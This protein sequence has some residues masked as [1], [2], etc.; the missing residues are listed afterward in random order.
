VVLNVGFHPRLALTYLNMPRK[1]KVYKLHI[2][3]CSNGRFGGITMKRLPF[4]ALLLMSLC[5]PTWAQTDTLPDGLGNEIRTPEGL[6]KVIDR[7][8][9][10]F[11]IVDVRSPAEYAA[12]HIPTAINI[13]G[14]ITANIKAPPS[15]D[16][17]IVAYCHGGMKAPTACEKLLSDGYKYVF[18][19]GGIVNW[20]YAKETASQ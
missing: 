6:R 3:S 9:P 13:P 20:P 2:A 11:V 17:Y 12:G 16:K 18:V 19:W 15:K 4:V 5:A 10:R 8:D 7:K 14:G 1:P